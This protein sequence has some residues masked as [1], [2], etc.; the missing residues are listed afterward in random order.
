MQCCMI[1]V[2]VQGGVDGLIVSNTTVSRPASLKN[3]THSQE[4][5]GLSGLPLR[6]MATETISDMYLL[7]GGIYSKGM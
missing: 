7:T 2:H 4:K 5:G 6:D 1:M 3:H